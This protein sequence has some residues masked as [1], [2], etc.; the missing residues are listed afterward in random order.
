MTNGQKSI[1]QNLIRQNHLGKIIWANSQFGK[2]I[3]WTQINW[4]NSE[5]MGPN[6]IGK[7]IIHFVKNQIGKNHLGKKSQNISIM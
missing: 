6:Q 3:K 5:N 2:K 1:G 7:N 4:A